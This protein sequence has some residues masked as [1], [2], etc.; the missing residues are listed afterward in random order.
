MTKQFSSYID[1]VDQIA[2]CE[3]QIEEL[4]RKRISYGHQ[5]ASRR[6]ELV[7][8]EAFEQQEREV[9]Q[10]HLDN[11]D[12]ECQGQDPPF[13][14]G[15]VSAESVFCLFPTVLSVAGNEHPCMKPAGHEGRC[16]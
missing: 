1:V 7:L 4:E 10:Q 13:E 5:A 8:L 9:M 16:E 12:A 6:H 14:V 11:N 2:I 15:Q 3:A